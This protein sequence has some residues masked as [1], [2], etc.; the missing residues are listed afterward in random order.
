M[1]SLQRRRS[2]LPADALPR[3]ARASAKR[4]TG[5]ELHLPRLACGLDDEKLSEWRVGIAGHVLPEWPGGGVDEKL[6]RWQRRIRADRGAPH[7]WAK[8]CLFFFLF[9]SPRFFVV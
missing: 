4:A 9:V 5:T 1:G 3:S 8:T 2:G 6:V 7:S